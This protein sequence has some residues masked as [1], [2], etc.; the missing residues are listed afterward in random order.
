MRLHVFSFLIFLKDLVICVNTV[1]RG[2]DSI[3]K[4]TQ[5]IR[6]APILEAIYVKIPDNPAD[7]SS[8]LEPSSE[9]RVRI[10]PLGDISRN[11]RNNGNLYERSS[12]SY[13]FD[14]N[15]GKKHSR[16]E[17]KED[18]K[19][20]FKKKSGIKEAAPCAYFITTDGCRFGDKCRY[21]HNA[22]TEAYT[23]SMERVLRH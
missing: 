14:Q 6:L 19:E 7:P 10:I 18:R 13:K 3:E 11:E 16:E 15:I 21:S 12:D 17:S 4:K 9:S 8:F 22:S 20:S 1:E 5:Q 23:K 2:R